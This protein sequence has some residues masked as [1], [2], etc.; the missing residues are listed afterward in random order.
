[1]PSVAQTARFALVA[2][3][4]DPLDP[5]DRLRYESRHATGAAWAGVALT[6]P[7]P[8]TDATLVRWIGAQATMVQDTPRARGQNDG[9]RASR[10]LAT[11][12]SK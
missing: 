9:G 11:P 7:V 3:N 2:K 10:G 1:M 4:Q 5:L 12:F 6:G 8:K